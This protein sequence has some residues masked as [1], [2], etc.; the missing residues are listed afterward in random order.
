MLSKST[1]CW[2]VIFFLKKK[3]NKGIF[4]ITIKRGVF[5]NQKD[6]EIMYVLEV[7]MLYMCSKLNYLALFEPYSFFVAVTLALHYKPKKFFLILGNIFAL[8]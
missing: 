3:R 8:H 6:W 7:S 2:E 1:K 4:E 5:R